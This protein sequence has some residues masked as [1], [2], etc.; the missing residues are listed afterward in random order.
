MSLD[1]LNREL[2]NKNLDTI[3]GHDHEKSLYDPSVGSGNLSSPFD[4]EENWGK[5]QKG[6][7]PQQKKKMWIAIAIFSVLLLA[8][9]G[10]F[11]NRWWTKN[12]FHQDRVSISFEGPKEA[13][14][15]QQMK[16]IIHYVNNNRVTLKEASIQLSYSKNF[17][18]T[19]NLN[20]K[21]L[22][23]TSSRIYIGDIKSMSEGSIELNGIFYAPKDSPVYLNGEIS[24]VPSNGIEK[25]S[26]TGKI[27]VNITAAPVVLEVSAPQQA[28][29]GDGLEYVIDYQ[30]IDTRIIKDIRVQVDF[31]QG[32]QF[33]TSQPQAS[34]KES[35]WYI[36]NLEAGQTGKIRVQG[37]I[38][39]LDGEGKNISVSLGHIGTDNKFIAY[40]KQE[41]TTRIVSPVLKIAQKMEDK[42]DDVVN[43]GELLKYTI[44]FEN[45]GDIGLR[46]AIISAEVSGK[47]LDFSKISVENGSYDGN[48]NIITWK[49]SE[50]PDLLNINPKAR[51]A[52]HFSVPIKNVIPVENKL[53]KNFI[54]SSVAKI[55]SP[56]IPTPI[57]ANKIIGSNKLELRLASKALFDVK[58]YYTDEKIKNS[59]PLPMEVGKETT[60]GIH[61]SIINVSNDLAG[62]KVVSALPNGIRWTG[63]V[64]PNDEKISY[65]ER[66]NQLV[67]EIGDVPA[68]TGVFGKTREIVFQV[69]VNPQVNQIG[70]GVPLVNKSIF[71]ATDTFVQRDITIEGDA[72]D[73]QLYEDQT[74]G[75]VNGKVAK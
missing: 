73:T 35:S 66:T 8:I 20:L 24:F 72:K 16:Y 74:V 64:Y 5:P 7:T 18:T 3:G 29:D 12:A 61:W 23:A 11:F 17:Q 40:S 63:Q 70:E 53:D 33:S 15:T 59:G 21:Y 30:N 42:V 43:A 25:L 50:V 34:E 9:G 55:D 44:S 60:F 68:G 1:D 38:K 41:V 57:D 14:S 51:G 36:G 69:G 6:L 52:V 2:Y 65:N 37:Q 62:A 13:D 49:A 75:Y 27:G 71:T 56:D 67:W 22:S 26:M 10:F 45:T 58:G 32:F 4:H 28:V 39:G 54:V 46:D 31:P 19:D 48:K 47:I